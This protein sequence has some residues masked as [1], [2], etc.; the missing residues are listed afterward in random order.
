M[1]DSVILEAE[2]QIKNFGID[3]FKARTVGCNRR[4]RIGFGDARIET[5]QDIS[6]VLITSPEGD[7]AFILTKKRHR[8]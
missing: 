2:M 6:T 1:K 7:T 8:T 3:F 5:V 4:I